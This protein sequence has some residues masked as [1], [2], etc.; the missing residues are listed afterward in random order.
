MLRGSDMVEKG[1]NKFRS[2]EEYKI[3]REG[4]NRDEFRGRREGGGT[5]FMHF[6]SWTLSNCSDLAYMV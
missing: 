5:R 4:G 3:E 2:C 1:Y 6:Q